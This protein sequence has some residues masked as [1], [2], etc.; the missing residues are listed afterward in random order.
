MDLA[1]SLTNAFMADDD[2][3]YETHYRALK[4][5]YLEQTRLGALHPF[6]IE[7]LA[8]YTEDTKEALK[9]YEQALDLS[10]AAGEPMHTIMVD[11]AVRLHELGRNEQAEAF[12]RDG[13]LEALQRRDQDTVKDADELLKALRA[14]SD[15]RT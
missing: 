4:E 7:T 14:S 3:L 2:V 13:R 8:D 10:R 9:Y 12:V 5:Y 6:L 1:C 11:M 15:E